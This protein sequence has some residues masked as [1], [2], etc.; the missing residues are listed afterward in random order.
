V[1]IAVLD[2]LKAIGGPGEFYFYPGNDGTLE[3]G[4]NKWSMILL[5][6]YE[7]AG[8]SLRS[9]AWRDT[10]VALGP[11]DE[12]AFL[13]A[14]PNPECNPWPTWALGRSISIRKP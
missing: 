13:R 8:I 3:T 12:K 2:E 4:K 11:S 7:K 1:P 9:R 6:I 10:L 14:V 5:P